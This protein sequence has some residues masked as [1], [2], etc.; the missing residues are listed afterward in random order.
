MSWE[1]QTEIVR[2]VLTRADLASPQL[3]E[4]TP[5]LDRLFGG[6]SRLPRALYYRWKIH[7]DVK[8]EHALHRG[9]STVDAYLELAIEAV[10]R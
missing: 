4:V 5:E 8:P 3:Y 6:P 2:T 9:R 1:D 7:L 10:A